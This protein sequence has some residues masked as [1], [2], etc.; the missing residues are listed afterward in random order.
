MRL[1]RHT[2]EDFS[3]YAGCELSDEQLLALRQA[4]GAMS[5]KMRAVRIIAATSVSK[6]DLEKR[7]IHKWEDPK[8]AKEAVQWMSDLKLVDDRATA[9]QIVGSCIR[10]GYG[11][12]RAKQ[13][14]YEKQIPKQ[15]WEEALTDYPDQMDVVVAYLNSHVPEDGDP[16]AVK[17]AIDA[18]LR[19]GHSYGV[20]RRALEQ[21]SVET[22][23]YPEG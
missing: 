17:K 6:K 20:I 14:L 11:V 21:I 8:Q 3:L 9:E 4:A 12:A 1:Y 13:A 2:L 16:K 18:L 22:E 5:A 19:R 10:K 15:Y 23:D 7:L